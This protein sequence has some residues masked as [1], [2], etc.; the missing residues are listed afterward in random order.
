MSFRDYFAKM[1]GGKG[2]PSLPGVGLAEIGWSWVGSVI[3]ISLCSYLS[4]QY[5]EPADLTLLLGSFGASAVLV[6][7]AI[8]SP[9]AQPRNLVGGHMI[10]GFIGVL[11][12]KLFSDIPWLAAGLGVSGAIVAMLLTRTLH[13][14][15]GATALLAVIGGAK[16]HALGYLYVFVP[17][18]AG[19]CLLLLVGLLVNN[20]AEHR[21][22]PE[23]WW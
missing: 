11:S 10:S 6:Y 13:P 21:R 4:S 17:A 20:L 22:Y 19:A 3:G 2:G 1:L 9:M 18:G 8:S 12:Y 5:F 14:P 23:Y 15:G 7:G 16:L